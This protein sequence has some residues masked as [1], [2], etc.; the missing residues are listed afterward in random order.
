MFMYLLTNQSFYWI[1]AET[2]KLQTLQFRSNVIF[3]WSFPKSA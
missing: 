3:T 1:A 2:I